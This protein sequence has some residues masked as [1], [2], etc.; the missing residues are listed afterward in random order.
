H[1][2]DGQKVF[3]ETVFLDGNVRAPVPVKEVMVN[4]ERVDPL[5]HS[6]YAFFSKRLKLAVGKND[7]KVTA[8]NDQAKTIERALVLERRKQAQD[9]VGNLLA[10]SVA[11]I[12]GRG[13]IE[14]LDVKRFDDEL[15]LQI[16]ATERFRLLDRETLDQILLE[17]K[18]VARG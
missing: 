15:V 9:D 11:E 8:S 6:K 4:G 2:Q 1:L 10:L 13:S 14:S 5:P 12:T 16:N 3:Q 7:I 17:H 18:L